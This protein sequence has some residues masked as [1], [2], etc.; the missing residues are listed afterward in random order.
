MQQNDNTSSR[1]PNLQLVVLIVLF[2]TI[3]IGVA[4]FAA[5]WIMEGAAQL[6]GP[7]GEFL[8]DKGADR[9]MRRCLLAVALIFLGFFLKMIGWSARCDFNFNLS[10]HRLPELAHGI[11][12]GLATFSGLSIAVWLLDVRV[13][14]P[15]PNWGIILNKSLSCLIAGISIGLL[16][17]IVCRGILFRSAAR[18]WRTWPAAIVSSAVFALAHFLTPTP[19]AFKAATPSGAVWQVYLNT[20]TNITQHEAFLLRFCNLTL[21]GVVLCAFLMYTGSLWQSIGAHATW[22]WAM[23]THDFLTEFNY[24]QP[25]SI[26]FGFRY[27]FTDSLVAVFILLALLATIALLPRRMP[28]IITLR[29]RGRRWHVAP[30]RVEELRSWL[31]RNWPDDGSG[32]PPF[33]DAADA[34][35][36]LKH[37]QG[38][39]VVALDGLIIKT[40]WPRRKL[41]RQCHHIFRVRRGFN[42]ARRLTAAGISTAAALGWSST[43]RGWRNWVGYLLTEELPAE[44][45]A[46]RLAR[47]TLPPAERAALMADYGRLT[48]SF[49]NNNYYNRDLKYENVMAGDAPARL[50]VVD[51]D[52]VRRKLHITR[53]RAERDL[54][55]IGDCLMTRGWTTPADVAAFFNGYNQ[56][57]P[58]RLRRNTFPTRR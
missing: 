21:L 49:H 25:V 7:I 16:E 43:W 17:E 40:Y 38:C 26:W 52:G 34:G 36:T 4:A 50:W 29:H 19:E 20:F 5:V 58:P 13:I 57:V 8:Q 30:E 51:L 18:L 54:F 41:L 14:K 3:G 53:R 28:P 33:T 1:P 11:L 55:R 24:N 47:P 44:P 37:Y 2:L 56:N 45:L 32:P 9:V 48:A 23:K 42:T 15:L 22:V 10:R 12:I 6:G 39:R 35:R 27:D 46:D 31:A